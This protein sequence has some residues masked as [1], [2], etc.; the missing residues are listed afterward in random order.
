M[1]T[2]YYTR[3]AKAI[4]G[5]LDNSGGEMPIDEM[6]AMAEIDLFIASTVISRLLREKKITYRLINGV[7][8]FRIIKG[9]KTNLSSFCPK[10]K[11][12]SVK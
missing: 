6:V 7:Q 4:L 2:I 8:H 3:E 9:G 1:E 5:V 10:N 11:P 12:S